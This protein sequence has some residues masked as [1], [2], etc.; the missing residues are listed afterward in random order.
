LKYAGVGAVQSP[1]QVVK[2]KL[3]FDH[4]FEVIIDVFA[5]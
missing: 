5:L 1:A 2:E 4:P 3:P